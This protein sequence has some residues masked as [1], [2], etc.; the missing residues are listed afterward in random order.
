M[1]VVEA[2]GASTDGTVL[3]QP[4]I[5]VDSLIKE[6]RT[7]VCSFLIPPT[8]HRPQLCAPPV[9]PFCDSCSVMLIDTEA[10]TANRAAMLRSSYRVVSLSCV[11]T[12]RAF[13]ARTSV[14]L[15]VADTPK[16]PPCL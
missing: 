15:I 7:P 12:A 2:S 14:D 6:L 11:A 3:S 16:R 9:C 4:A 10:A 13:L 1:L 5:P 8:H